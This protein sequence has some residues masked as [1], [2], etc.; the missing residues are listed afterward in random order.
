MKT[1]L[2]AIVWVAVLSLAAFRSDAKPNILHIVADDLGWK[3]VGFNGAADI[4]TPNLDRLAAGGA[5]LSQFYSQH[6]CTPARACMMTGRYPFRYG[7]QTVVIP[8]VATYG[9]ATN[10]VL[11]PEV[12]KD[13]GYRTAIRSEEH[14]SEL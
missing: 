10:E 9:L 6:I 3:D 11:L 4:K 7:L 2:F 12:L 8:S 1:T 13:A 5:V 14:T